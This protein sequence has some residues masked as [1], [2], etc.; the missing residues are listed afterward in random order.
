MSDAGISIVYLTY[1]GKRPFRHCYGTLIT[2]SMLSCI[3]FCNDYSF[4]HDP[5][6]V[7]CSV[8]LF[9]GVEI[10]W[11]VYPSNAYSSAVLLC[12]HLVILWGLWSAPSKYP[13]ADDQAYKEE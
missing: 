9:I 3:S 7:L 11:N 6:F 4:N 12:L 1:C 13:Y 5:F 8:I 2:P 10:C